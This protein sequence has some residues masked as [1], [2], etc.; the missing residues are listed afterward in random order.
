MIRIKED[1]EGSSVLI[2]DVG[3]EHTNPRWFS[4]AVEAQLDLPKFFG[5]TVSH[6]DFDKNQTLIGFSLKDIYGII[7]K[8]ATI[9]NSKGAR[10]SVVLTKTGRAHLRCV[11]RTE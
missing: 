3:I 6:R 7:L 4:N 10:F 5:C 11:C 2:D 8:L 1:N 9:A